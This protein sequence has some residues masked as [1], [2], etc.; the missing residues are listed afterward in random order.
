MLLCV[1]SPQESVLYKQEAQ[2]SQTD[3]ATLH[4]IEYFALIVSKVDYCNSVLAGI[5]GQLQER[6]QS[7][8]NA[9]ARL[10]FS[11]KRSERITPLLRELHWMLSTGFGSEFASR[12]SNVCTRWLLKAEYLSTYCQPVSG[13]SGRRHAPA[14]GWPCMLRTH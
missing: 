4:V 2:L 12:C 3:G 7:V 6:L 14:I 1:G 10:V 8:L 13:I 5:T 9:V 11:A